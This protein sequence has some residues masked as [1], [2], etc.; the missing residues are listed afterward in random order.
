MEGDVCDP[1][2]VSAEHHTR[3]RRI[4]RI[5]TVLV[6]GVLVE[7]LVL[8]QLAGARHAFHLLGR[9]EPGWLVLGALL[10][11][12]AIASYAEL[13]RTLLPAG[14][15][16]TRPTILR[17]T[18]TTLGLSHVVP[19]GTAVGSSLGIRLLTGAGVRGSDAAFAIAAEGI[20]SAVV[21]NVMLWIGLLISIP[22]RGFNPVYGTAA[23]VGALLL[24]AV[25]VAVALLTK[26]EDRLADTVC[27]T[28]GRVPFLDGEVV[29]GALRRF[30]ER[31]RAL[32]ANPRVLARAVLW[33]GLNWMFDAAALWVF[34]AAF[35]HHVG[36]D[37][38]VISFGIANVLA[39][40]PITPGGLGVV[41]GV[42]TALLV[43]FGT[44][45]AVAL[46]GIVSYRLLNFWLPIPL[47]AVAYLS[48][49]VGGADDLRDAAVDAEESAPRP[50][51][52]A[53]QRGV[54]V[55]RSGYGRVMIE[56][57][58]PHE[59]DVDLPDE[60]GVAGAPE[61]E[62]GGLGQSPAGD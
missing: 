20:G 8:P 13:T 18:L 47:G 3:R 57:P 46:L 49:R 38:L 33:A 29:A 17:I 25:G 27:R 15:R 6:I 48:L 11:A 52:W 9:V 7:Y 1:R 5:V 16:P 35:G 54:R 30:A 58:R 23:V 61:V 51:E 41:E 22:L 42:L 21:L 24:A 14:Q 50:L 55:P 12:A 10:E 39:A 43:G 31:L 60:A 59:H 40:V 37:G 53:R 4:R 19:G 32:A 56:Q 34:L 45:R 44:P 26:G 28:A 2:C 36:L 62:P